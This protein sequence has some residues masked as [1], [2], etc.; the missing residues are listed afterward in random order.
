[1]LKKI[2]FFIGS[3]ASDYP[4][5]TA[6]AISKNAEG[7]FYLDVFSSVGSSG[8]SYF[9]GD[10]DKRSISLP[11][12]KDYAGIII[13][14]DS[15]SGQNIYEYLIQ[16]I[17]KEA[18]CPVICLRYR[19]DRFYNILVDDYS[20]MESVVRHFIEVHHCKKICHMTGRMELE[21]ARLRLRSYRD[22]MAK[23]NLP[24]TEHMI[25]EGNYWT[26]RG[27]AAVD[28][29]LGDESGEMPEA[30][31]CAN[32]YMAL[33]VNEA[34][35]KRGI[36][37]PED[38]RVSGFD[39]IREVKY[40]VPRIAS[41][42]V[43]AEE[44]GA[45][46]I[47]LLERL[48]NGEAVEQNTYVPVT[49]NFE[50]SCGCTDV[51]S[52]IHTNEL[53]EEIDYLNKAMKVITYMNWDYESCLTYEELFYNAFRYSDNFDYE[54]IYICLCEHTQ[55][56]DNDTDDNN[57]DDNDIR[58][59]YSENMILYSI[60]SQR[61]NSYRFLNEVFPRNEILPTKYRDDG[62]A[63][64]VFPLH[65]KNNCL[66]Y[67]ALKAEHVEK[68]SRFFIFWIQE[69][70]E[71]IDKIDMQHKS[72]AYYEFVQQSRLD[73]LTGLY[74]RREMENILRRKKYDPNKDNTFYIMSLDMD[75]LKIINDTYGH[76]EGDQALLAFAEILKKVSNK[77][78]VAARTGGDEFL[79]C[80]TSD[81][82]EV[83][84][85][86]QTDILNL[87]DACNRTGKKPY[88]LS[89]SIGY[90]R[91]TEGNGI[92]GCMKEADEK[93]YADKSTKKNTRASMSYKP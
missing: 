27:E 37:V 25:F 84:R 51:S 61:D 39:N 36:R 31:V 9:H 29:F 75:G 42:N 66:G 54:K 65:Y 76:I 62:K 85:R 26:D 1:M 2:A 78:V 59:Q 14:P 72:K 71:G 63:V 44:M 28:W 47:D 12:L 87:L 20:A 74:N 13:D 53:L 68:L 22:T 91:F 58:E 11:D 79:L 16:K 89:A 60:F 81:D 3:I 43:P 82:E 8:E 77:N 46:A 90:A 18:I 50:G 70:A 19:D 10:S 5:K 6:Y 17:V 45:V 15:F 23:Y 48:N 69:M 80:I 24:V 30:I 21:D 32:D 33:S 35:K 57:M 93:M 86:I 34:L 38:I 40:S 64:F 4:G 52:T 56:A 55:A 41:M 7:K 67:V 88:Q 92:M 73:A 49:A 83:P